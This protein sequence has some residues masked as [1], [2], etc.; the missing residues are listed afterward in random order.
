MQRKTKGVVQLEWVCP[1]CDGRNPGPAKTCANCGAPQPENIQFQRA[2][3]EKLITDEKV[4]QSA[5][6][7]ADIHCGF[8]GTRNPATAATCSQC[9]GD[10]KE[11]KSRQAGQVMQ[12]A[13]QTPKVITC[14]NCG[15][16]NPGS[17]KT[18][19]TCGAPIKAP[20][21]ATVA[22]SAPAAAQAG[23]MPASKPKAKP[24]NW[25]IAGGIGG[26]FLLCCVAILFMFVFPSR[27]VDGT[28]SSVYWKTS[29][30]VQ[31]VRAVDYNN[32][33]GSPPSDAYNVSCRTES[34]EVC[35]QKTVDQGNGYAEV[36]EEC[37]TE[38]EQYCSYT[39]DEWTTIQT[40]DLEGYDSYPQYAEPSV[41]SGQRIGDSTQSFQVTFSTSDGEI[42]Y[43]PDS[44]AE[45]QQ[46]QPGSSWTLKL[47]ALGGVVGVE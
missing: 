23:G 21:T 29:V 16:E 47:N 25:L 18:C 20:A 13:P 28:V 44:A 43:S 38:T 1:N 31:E 35:E 4:V 42:N 27:S 15:T 41:F 19:S 7:G 14:A 32:E 6:A 12:A 8:C 45:F 9:G 37:H 11:G 26:F 3:D 2:A 5:K 22:P 36:V 40:Y 34:E 24:F 17:A 39:V 10:L 46:F 30:P 33:R